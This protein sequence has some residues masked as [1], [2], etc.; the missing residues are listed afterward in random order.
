MADIYTIRK[1]RIQSGCFPGFVPAENEFFRASPHEAEHYVYLKAVDSGVI[2]A[3]W[4]RL[5]TDL[6]HSEDM[7]FYLRAVALNEDSFYRRGEPVRIQD[8]LCDPK[9]SPTVK[10]EFFDRVGAL[11]TV[12]R[13]DILL[14]GL[15]G[16]YLY[17]M[18]EA[19]GEGSCAFS[20]ITIDRQGDNFMNTFPGVYQ[21]RNSF[22]HRYM[23]VFSSMY[24]DFEGK[25]DSLPQ[26]LDPGKCPAALLPMYASWLGLDVGDDF[27]DE[28][29]LRPLVK[30]AYALNRMKGTKAALERIGEI[31]LGQKVQVLERNVMADYIEPEQMREFE[32]LYGDS[33]YDV[34]VL[35]KGSATQLEISRLLFLME[36]FKPVRARLHIIRMEKSGTLDQYSYLDMNAGISDRGPGS[37]DEKKTLDGAVRLSE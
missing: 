18:L 15:R 24:N 36:Q 10:R 5:R 13:T 30:E 31:V 33:V 4:G 8:F 7:I 14:Y 35:V 16:R 3:E 20:T 21:E 29:I 34:T 2:D 19:D 6:R 37:L 28:A 27:L 23:S 9:E 11:R 17:L 1:N 22:F 12:N 26:L 25:I 32:K